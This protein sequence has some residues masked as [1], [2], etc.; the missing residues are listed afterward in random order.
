MEISEKYSVV[1]GFVIVSI[2]MATSWIW[3][4]RRQRRMSWIVLVIVVTNV[5]A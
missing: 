1:V 5:E 4:W 2:V 3:K